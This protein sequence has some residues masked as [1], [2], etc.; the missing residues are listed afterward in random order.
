M[1]IAAGEDAFWDSVLY[2]QVGTE[3]FQDSFLRTDGFC[4]RHVTGFSRCRDGVA[5]TMLYA[6]LM[7]HRRRWIAELEKRNIRLPRPDRLKG[8]GSGRN[9]PEQLGHKAHR[10]DCPLC[11]RTELWT[12]QFLTN[13]LRHQHI[14]EL[15]ESVE[16]GSGL[17]M[18]HYRRMAEIAA[19]GFLRRTP[20]IRPWLQS[21]HHLRWDEA[22]LRAEKETS[23]RGGSAWNE[24][25]RVMEGEP[26]LRS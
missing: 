17:C 22:V 10:R 8:I 15:Q 20:R 7:R 19:T 12:L 16:K 24:L 1:S 13:L 18:P 21:H 23:A 3:G 11:T 4:P 9:R 6:P 2:G 26:A 14:A 25:L 5:V